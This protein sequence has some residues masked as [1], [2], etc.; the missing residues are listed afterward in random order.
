MFWD[1]G[2]H[3]LASRLLS[4]NLIIHTYIPVKNNHFLRSSTVSGHIHRKGGKAFSDLLAME[5][6]SI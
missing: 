4:S 1:F 3:K 2:F 6:R 5:V